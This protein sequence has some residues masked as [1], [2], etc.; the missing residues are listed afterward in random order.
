MNRVS[1]DII[2]QSNTMFRHHLSRIEMDVRQ[3]E[4]FVAVAEELN[5]TR[6]AARCHVVQ[7]ALSHQIGR[8]EHENGVTLLERT[9]RSVR[10]APAGELLLPRARAVLSEIQRA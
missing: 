9:S 8:L 5:F 3:L 7:S 4:Y 10:L 6:A 1:G 2:D